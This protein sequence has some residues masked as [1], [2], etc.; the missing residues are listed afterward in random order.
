MTAPQRPR[1]EWQIE[2][3]PSERLRRDRDG[4]VRLLLRV[5][6]QGEHAATVP[7]ILTMVEAEGLHAQLCYAL[8]GEPAPLGA[9]ECRQLAQYPGGRRRF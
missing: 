1:G 9:P 7:L 3:L 4:H 2:A 5:D 8:D 6:H